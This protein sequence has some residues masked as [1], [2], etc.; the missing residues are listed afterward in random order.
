[1]IKLQGSRTLVL[2]YLYILPVKGCGAELD[3]RQCQ[4]FA[5]LFI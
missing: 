2:K 4:A 5:P 3:E 1:M